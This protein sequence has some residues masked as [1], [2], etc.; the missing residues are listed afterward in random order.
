MWVARGP[1]GGRKQA[2]IAEKDWE[3]VKVRRRRL[4]FSGEEWKKGWV[5]GTQPN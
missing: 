2:L 3:T 4:C 1:G 5:R